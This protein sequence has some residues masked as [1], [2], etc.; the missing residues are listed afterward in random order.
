M[1]EV[2]YTTHNL[3]TKRPPPANPLGKV[4]RQGP[5]F[6]GGL[7]QGRS[8]LNPQKSAIEGNF[9]KDLGTPQRIWGHP[10]PPSLISRAQS[11]VPKTK[12]QAPALLI[13]CRSCC[14]SSLLLGPALRE[15][16]APRKTGTR[17]YPRPGK[18]IPKTC[19]PQ[20]TATETGSLVIGSR[21]PGRSRKSN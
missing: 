6:S 5:P 9:S 10:C 7:P 16:P 8:S 4:G 2:F 14:P 11:R 15:Q 3:G 1:C 12:C 17:A 18:T 21:R 13:R 20:A 19:S